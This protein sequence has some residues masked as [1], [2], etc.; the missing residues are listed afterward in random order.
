MSDTEAQEFLDFD[1]TIVP[2]GTWDPP[3]SMT[4][5]LNKHFN[6]CLSDIER[7]ATLSHFPRPKED[8]Q[9]ALPTSHEKLTPPF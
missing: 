9:G 8:L 4:A 2:E 5:F 7:E 6:H 1:P 3:E